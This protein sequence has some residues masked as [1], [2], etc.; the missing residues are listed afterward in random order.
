[1]KDQRSHVLKESLKDL[2][3]PSNFRPGSTQKIELLRERAK[4]GKPLFVAGEPHVYT[5]PE[6]SMIGVLSEPSAASEQAEN[7]GQPALSKLSEGPKR[8]QSGGHAL[9]SRHLSK[10][11]FRSERRGPHRESGYAA[12]CG[13]DSLVMPKTHDV[14]Q[15][16][17]KALELLA[18]SPNS[19]ITG[20]GDMLAKTKAHQ[21]TSSD[22]TLAL[23]AA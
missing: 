3:A 17:L 16:V 20:V 8:A 2:T 21:E 11:E 1:M 22:V 13:G 6:A 7:I 14:P 18:Q 19:A 10:Q 5:S 12:G 15:D 4:R 23:P 9:R